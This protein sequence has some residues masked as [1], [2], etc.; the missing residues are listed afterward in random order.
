MET[1]QQV[2]VLFVCTGNICRSPMAEGLLRA[3]MPAGLQERMA[4]SSAGTSAIDGHP[5]SVFAVEVLREIGV[6]ISGHRSRQLR[7][8]LIAAA[9]VIIGLT[10][11][12]AAEVRRLVP[13]AGEKTITLASLDP[14]RA[15]EDVE[16]PIGG[17]R[18]T[19]ARIRDEIDALIVQVVKYLFDKYNVT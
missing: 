10:R 12:H 1:K 13:E 14:N 9:D 3:R 19:Y 5:A 18:E 4:V 15:S 6:D 8:E 2:R 17:T 11:E 16:D 7:P